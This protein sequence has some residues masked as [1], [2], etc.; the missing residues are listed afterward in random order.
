MTKRIMIW[1]VNCVKINVLLDYLDILPLKRCYSSSRNVHTVHIWQ[2][3]MMYLFMKSGADVYLDWIM[4]AVK[5]IYLEISLES[6]Y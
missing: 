6:S 2:S 3:K 1:Q 4:L 5:E